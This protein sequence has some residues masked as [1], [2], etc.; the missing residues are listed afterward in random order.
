MK[1]LRAG[2]LFHFLG[3][4]RFRRPLPGTPAGG[5]H[6]SLRK[7]SVFERA[8]MRLSRMARFCRRI[9]PALAT[10]YVPCWQAGIVLEDESCA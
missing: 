6:E 9:C 1:F 8:V 4:A 7:R 2:A 5:K 3:R 10:D